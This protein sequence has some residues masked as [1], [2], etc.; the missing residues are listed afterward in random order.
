MERG[1]GTLDF[2]ASYTPIE[3]LTI[4][5]DALNLLAGRDPLRRYR[6]FNTAGDT[7]PW[8]VKYLERVF[9]IGVRFRFS[10]GARVATSLPPVA[11][12][13]PPVVEPA[14]VEQPAPPPPPP[15]TPERG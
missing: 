8:N 11:P 5:F 9:S 4:A 6:A 3:N 10:G 13:P 7:Y 14:P 1:H 15:P 12:P 2:S